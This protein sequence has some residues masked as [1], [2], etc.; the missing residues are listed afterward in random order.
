MTH[1]KHL[2]TL[3]A[4]LALIAF[5]LGCGGEEETEAEE[6]PTAESPPEEMAEEV[7]EEVEEAVEETEEAVADEG[8]GGTVCERAT[9]CCEAYVN[10]LSAN[11][12]GLSVET[13][14][15]SVR[16]LSGSPGGDT[17]CQSA[18]D[19][20]RQGLEAAQMEVPGPCAAE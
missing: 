1:F 3:L 19:G 20:W 14:C 9:S 4:M 13:T 5:P 12:P 7:E 15:Q 16:Q 17:A 18:I 2:T 10:A 8:G 6:T 11:T